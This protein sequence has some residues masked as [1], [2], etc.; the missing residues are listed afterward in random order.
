MNSYTVTHEAAETRLATG[1][2]LQYAEQGDSTAQ[3]MILLHGL[4]DSWFSYSRVLPA[5]AERYHVFALSQRGHGDSARPRSGYSMAD[6][7]A[8]VVAFMDAQGLARATVVGHSMSSLIAQ[9][10]AI[11]APE[12]VTRLVLIGAAANARNIVGGAEFQAVVHILTDPVSPDFVREFQVSTIHVPVPD[13]FLDRAVEESLKLPAR[14]WHAAVDGM[15]AADYTAQLGQIQ[16]PTLI[17]WGD[18]DTYFPRSEQDV[19]RAGLRQ[20]TLTVYPATGHALQWER[21]AQFVRDL[22]EFIG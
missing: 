11:D 5:L 12:R 4:S 2:R 10:V 1:V 6:F 7:A 19:L 14:V 17:F 18:Q 15:L 3:P 8:D 13:A 9:Q 21:P 22:T 16:A 20:A